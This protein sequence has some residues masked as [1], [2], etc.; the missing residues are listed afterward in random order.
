MYAVVY[1][2]E[3]ADG[4]VM[5]TAKSKRIIRHDQV[6]AMDPVIQLRCDTWNCP[7]SLLWPFANL[8]ISWW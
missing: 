1:S 6:E 3:F 8:I 2:L 5:W 7:P 4:I